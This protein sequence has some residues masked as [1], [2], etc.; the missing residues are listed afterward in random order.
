MKDNI[1]DCLISIS[2][3][4]FLLSVIVEKITQL[5][6][7][8]SPFIRPGN[9]LHKTFATRIW[10]NLNKKSKDRGP[11]Q[12]KK[13][14]REVTSLSLIIGI[15]IAGIFHID[16]F[17]MLKEPDPRTVIFWDPLPDWRTL[18]DFRLLASIG[19][20]GFFLTFGSKFFHDLLDMLYQV[21]NIKRKLA[22]ENTFNAEDIEQ[23]DEYVSKRYGSIIQ[24]A[25]SQ[26]LSALSP[27]GTMAPPMHGK[28]MEKGKLVDCIDV[29]VITG[30]N[31]ILPAKVEV[32]LEKGQVILVPV[33][34]VP[35][36]GNP[37]SVQS[38]QGDPVG[39]GSQSTLDGTICCQVRRNS[40]NK[41]GL[42]TCSHVL[43]RGGSTN[44]FGNI[45]PPISGIVDQTQNGEFFWAVCN[46]KLD[47]ALI[48]IPNDNFS[49]IHPTKNA[50]PVTIADIKVTKV[51]I[52]RQKGRVQKNG[53]IINANVPIPIEI[54]YSDGNFGVTNLMLLS[55]MI[56]KNGVTSYSSL[57]FPG[58][59]GACVYD[60]HEHPIGMVIA[61]D[62]NFTYAL[63]LV[64]I[65]KEAGSVIQIN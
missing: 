32:K 37:P 30:N 29:R 12:E 11:E 2:I 50:R 8:Y 3:I 1:L 51:S 47:A 39:P 49:Y 52:I 26:N 56:T 10:R 25:I 33:N 13:I 23:F 9:V 24:D 60:E 58:D 21:K 18:L 17:E 43:E 6:R 15:L 63:P 48:N 45:S 62:S 20:T 40:D 5:I 42:L 35:V 46:S 55:K 65:L 19:L 54:K 38:K 53:T 61:A 4:L 31:P 14:E 36:Q 28:M 44:H 64:D 34:Q 16:L 59:S 7:K 27:K 57:S 22:D 41:L